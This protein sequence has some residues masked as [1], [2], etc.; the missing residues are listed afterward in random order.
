VLTR[1]ELERWEQFGATWRVVS[2]GADR[3]L[4]DLCT[5]TGELVERRDDLDPALLEDLRSLPPEPVA[6]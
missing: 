6:G 5:C 2:L 4:V 3:G 1:E